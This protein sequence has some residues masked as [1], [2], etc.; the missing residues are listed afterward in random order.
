MKKV[1]PNP[2]PFEKILNFFFRMNPSLWKE[3]KINKPKMAYSRDLAVMD[4]PE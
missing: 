2:P 3:I 1:C 4:C